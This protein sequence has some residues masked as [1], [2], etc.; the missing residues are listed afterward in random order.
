M[1]LTWYA[2]GSEASE[3]EHRAAIAHASITCRWSLLVVTA[4]SGWNWPR[5]FADHAMWNPP[6]LA[7]ADEWLCT[8][9]WI[10]EAAGAAGCSVQG[11]I[12]NRSGELR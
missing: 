5:E 8:C 7:C 4:S 3:A 1:T 2:D 9:C 11:S 12:F 6:R 10:L